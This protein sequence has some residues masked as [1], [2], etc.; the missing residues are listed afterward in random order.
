MVKK[1]ERVAK[2]AHRASQRQQ[3]VSEEIAM[4]AFLN[5]CQ[6]VMPKEVW[7]RHYEE[8]SRHAGETF[9]IVEHFVFVLAATNVPVPPELRKSID[10]MLDTLK[11]NR[12]DCNWEN[13][14]RLNY[15]KYWRT[16]YGYE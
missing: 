10:M 7:A 3:H 15:G 9:H 1:A 16:Q 4:Q 5:E 6:A 14:R 8:A 2:A 12:G 13:L 11:M